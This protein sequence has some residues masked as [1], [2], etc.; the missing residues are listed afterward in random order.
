[1]SK[2]RGMWK[3]KIHKLPFPV[4]Q[5]PVVNFS[6]DSLR[7][8]QVLSHLLHRHCCNV[9]S[10]SVKKVLKINTLQMRKQFN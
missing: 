1:V 4:E 5:Q 6:K 9:H 2:E 8:G 3:A 10:N 7:I